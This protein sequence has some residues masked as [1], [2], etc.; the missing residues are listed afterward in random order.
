M[1]FELPSSVYSPELLDSV[2]YEL[3]Q[4]LAW[5]RQAKVQQKV[6]ARPPAEPSYSAETSQVI[7]AWLSDKK[8]SMTAIEELQAHLK[9]LK[10]PVVHVTLAALP[11]HTQRTQLVD[12]FRALAQH[13]MLISFV[14]D[15]TLGG[16]IVVRTPNRIFDMSWR[17]RLVEGRS[18]LGEIVTRV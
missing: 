8:P 6:G 12:W 14:A 3:E 2:I 9:S 11:N 15:R 18:K 17:Q 13:P 5:Y 10:L 7:K 16:G 1:A 4:Y